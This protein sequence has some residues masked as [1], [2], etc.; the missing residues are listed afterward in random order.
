[1]IWLSYT[2]VGRPALGDGGD[3]PEPQRSRRTAKTM[4]IRNPM[5][6]AFDPATSTV[7]PKDPVERALWAGIKY[8]HLTSQYFN[9]NVRATAERIKLVGPQ[10]YDSFKLIIQNSPLEVFGTKELPATANSRRYQ[11]LDDE[12]WQQM[13]RFVSG[14]ETLE[15]VQESSAASAVAQGVSR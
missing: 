3:A 1:M 6:C 9:E 14:Q 4:K 15:L 12:F 5:P 11:I 7:C 8:Q 2:A 10:D 13:W